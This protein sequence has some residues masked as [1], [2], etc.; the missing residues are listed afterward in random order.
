M[1]EAVATLDVDPEEF[2]RLG[3]RAVDLATDYL[4]KLRT[5]TN[6]VYQPMSVDAQNALLNLPLLDEALSAEALLDAFQHQIMTNPMGN[7]HPSFF[8]WVNS[9]PA[10]IGIIAEFLAATMNPSCAGGNHAAIYL[11]H[12]IVGWLMDLLGFPGEDSYGLLVSGGSMASLTC[13]AA[14]RHASIEKSG[15]NVRR[16]GLQGRVAPVVL[17]LA[18]EGH[19]TM[20]KAAEL[21][22][23]GR[24][25]VRIIPVDASYRMDVAA[26]REAIANDRNAGLEPFCVAASAG[27]ASTGAV[28]PLDD[29]ADIC[30]REHLWFHVDGAYGGFGVLD[31]T[32]ALHFKGMERA[33]SIAIDPHKW[34]SVPVECGCAL[35][36][37]SQI[38]RETFSLVP[39][40]VQTEEGKG[41]GGLPWFSE[42]GF[43]Q[44][45]GFRGLKLW[46]VL[47][48]L[49]RSGVVEHVSRS[50][51]QA[52]LFTELI[53]EAPDFE[54]VVKR[55][56]SIVCFRYRPTGMN[57]GDEALNDLNRQIMYSL[58]ESG[59]LFLTQA[60]LGNRFALRACFI[61][62]LTR[63]EHVRAILPAVR[64]A[65]AVGT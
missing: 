8:G 61:N 58:Q 60:D 53:N 28:D 54:L 18:A 55:T 24:A 43:Q 63:D 27:T 44:T 35:V 3:Y 20:L 46:M 21:L 4:N 34:L 62:Y 45:R 49:G 29:I 39:S 23:I 32:V 31:P 51:C 16:D 40:Y 1:D 37:H 56:L 14:A 41:I 11:E 36:R 52:A 6:P 42:Y 25:N 19:T 57:L 26:L 15:G 48:Q 50:N 5:G 17:Y 38:L 7:G 65:V 10:P 12:A 30:A 13:L 59:D 9:P 64:R 47:A 22:G 2:R 33:D